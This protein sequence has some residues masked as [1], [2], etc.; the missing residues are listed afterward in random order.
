ML[1]TENTNWKGN[2]T[3]WLTSFLFCLELAA[4]FKLNEQQFYMFGQIQTSQTGGQLLHLVLSGYLWLKRP[5]QGT[6][7]LIS[8]NSKKSSKVRFKVESVKN[9]SQGR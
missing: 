2:I 7:V 9:R 4:L 8:Y 6:F 3:V 5:L 1:F